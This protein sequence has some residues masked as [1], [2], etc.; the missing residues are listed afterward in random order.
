M[1]VIVVFLVG[2]RECTLVDNVNSAVGYREL[3]SLEPEQLFASY[4]MNTTAGK[5]KALEAYLHLHLKL[6]VIPEELFDLV[7]PTQVFEHLYDP[8]LAAQNVFKITRP[9]GMLV[10]TAPQISVFHGVPDHFFGYTVQGIRVVLEKAG[11]CV[12][13]ASGLTSTFA[14]ASNLLGFAA[15]DMSQKV[16]EQKDDIGSCTIGVVAKKPEVGETCP[17]TEGTNVQELEDFR[18]AWAERIHSETV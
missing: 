12:L 2:F 4:D 7:L 15:Q 5:Q 6:G 9:G 13:E 17:K 16:L 1:L 18:N 10:L 11:F 14:C 3:F 8:Y